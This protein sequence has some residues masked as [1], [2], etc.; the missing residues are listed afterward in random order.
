MKRSVILVLLGSIVL[1]M[2]CGGCTDKKLPSANI[3]QDGADMLAPQQVQ[4]AL[5]QLHSARAPDQLSGLMFLERF[6]TVAQSQV[7]QVTQL[8]NSGASDSVKKKAAALLEKSHQ[9][10]PSVVR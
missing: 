3:P 2:V 8:A 9:G 7:E 1:P 10:S 6:P 4:A 5:K